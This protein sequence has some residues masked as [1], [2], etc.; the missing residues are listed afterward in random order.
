MK[1]FHSNILSF[2]ILFI[3]AVS[4]EHLEYK[5]TCRVDSHVD[6]SNVKLHFWFIYPSFIFIFIQKL[7]D[8]IQKRWIIITILYHLRWF[9]LNCYIKIPPSPNFVPLKSYFDVI[10]ISHGEIHQGKLILWG[11]FFYLSFS[12]IEKASF[13]WIFSF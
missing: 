11:L 8:K 6:H 1:T 9:C 13:L 3:V 7:C 10:L 4:I 12:F 2:Q 5:R